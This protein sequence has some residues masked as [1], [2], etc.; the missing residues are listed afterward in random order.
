MK[1]SNYILLISL[2]MAPAMATT[3][4]EN[5][6][7]EQ[8][9]HPL[10]FK[11]ISLST[12]IFG[13]AYSIIDDYMSGEIALEANFGNRIYPVIEVGYG[14]TDTYDDI[15]GIHYKSSAP[16]YRV[17]L[18]Y[19]FSTGKNKVPI[20]Y[21]YGL[22]RFGWT[23]AEYDLSTPPINDQMWGGGVPLEL[24]DIENYCSW[25]E[26]GVGVKVKIWKNFHMGW[27]IR[28]KARMNRTSGNNSR[29]W[30]VP[31]FGNSRHTLWGGTYNLIYELPM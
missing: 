2:L 7:E 12:D 31:G 20:N 11:G 22:A 8:K 28:Y 13:Y 9:E 27:S 1:I 16:F 17:G 5:A 29:M 24:T 15:L 19:N 18:N 23:R 21:I 26:L 25:I 4:Q 14:H 6:K 30:Y 3:A 10:A